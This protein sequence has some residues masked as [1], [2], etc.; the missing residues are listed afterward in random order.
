M[1]INHHHQQQQQP[2][3]RQGNIKDN[4]GCLQHETTS[5]HCCLATVDSNGNTCYSSD[6]KITTFSKS[7]SHVTYTF[8]NLRGAVEVKRDVWKILASTE[9]VTNKR[10]PVFEVHSFSQRII[11]IFMKQ[12]SGSVE[13]SE[14]AIIVRSSAFWWPATL[15]DD[16][17]Y[18]HHH[19][20]QYF[21]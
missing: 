16:D 20:H 3:D 8:V 7:G 4:N 9:P 10:P 2:A 13:N 14:R 21:V 1:K 15:N 11:I 5:S 19:H 12:P 17:D 6:R 18:D